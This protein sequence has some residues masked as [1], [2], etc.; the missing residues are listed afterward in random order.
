MSYYHGLM[1]NLQLSKAVKDAMDEGAIG[2]DYNLGFR[3][4]RHAAAEAALEADTHLEGSCELLKDVQVL[5]K[6]GAVSDEA[7]GTLLSR[8]EYAIKSLSSITSAH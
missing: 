5:L 4:A 8:V 1:M 2:P 3:D 7:C 6:S